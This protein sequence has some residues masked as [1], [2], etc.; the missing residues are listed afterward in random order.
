MWIYPALAADL[1]GLL[2]HQIPGVY[3]WENQE[4]IPKRHYATNNSLS[5]SHKSG[6][7]PAFILCPY[8]SDPATAEI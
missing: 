4:N 6:R 3:R 1:L 2:F 5:P 8:I 7:L